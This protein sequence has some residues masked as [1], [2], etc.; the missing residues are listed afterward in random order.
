MLVICWH[1]HRR[2][3]VIHVH[4]L[5]ILFQACRDYRH[6][7]DHDRISNVNILNSSIDSASTRDRTIQAIV[8]LLPWFIVRLYQL[9]SIQHS[10]LIKQ[11]NLICKLSLRRKLVFISFWSNREIWFINH[12]DTIRKNIKE[13]WWI[14]ISTSR[15]KRKNIPLWNTAPIIGSNNDSFI[16]WNYHRVCHNQSHWLMTLQTYNYVTQTKS[17][18][19][20]IRLQ[21]ETR[22][23]IPLIKFSF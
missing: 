4:S 17:A 10:D 21:R 14:F 1:L 19:A 20:T 9:V 5:H 12:V 15:Q 16:V 22:Y 7:I 13:P 6:P 18:Q 2:Q 23:I 3:L 11:K 8:F